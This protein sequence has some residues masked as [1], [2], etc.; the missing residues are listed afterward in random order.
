MKIVYGYWY[1]IH[2][3]GRFHEDT[4]KCARNWQR[5]K[6]HGWFSFPVN[7]TAVDLSNLH[8]VVFVLV[9]YSVHMNCSFWLM[10]WFDSTI[11]YDYDWLNDSWLFAHLWPFS[12]KESCHCN[13]LRNTWL[14]AV[15]SKQSVA[16]QS[17]L[18]LKKPSRKVGDSKLGKSYHFWGSIFVFQTVPSLGDFFSGII[19]QLQ[20]C[21]LLFSWVHCQPHISTLWP[22]PAGQIGYQLPVQH[23]P[24]RMVPV[25]K[26]RW[27]HGVPDN[28]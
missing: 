17:A 18:S 15:H 11:W 8:Y 1:W 25:G 23:L 4:T 6:H 20:S 22:E 14:D 24:S 13:P 19:H 9:Y 28:E 5:S 2:F 27:S 3:L 10:I 7:E 26:K 12:C 16:A 21:F